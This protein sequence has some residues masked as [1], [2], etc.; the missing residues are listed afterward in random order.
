VDRASLSFAIS[1]INQMVNDIRPS[2][3]RQ[4]LAVASASLPADLREMA[5]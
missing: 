2:E 4:P 3:S 1:R 5:G